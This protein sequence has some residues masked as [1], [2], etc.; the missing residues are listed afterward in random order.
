LVTR[1][2][3][4]AASGAV[5]GCGGSAAPGSGTPAGIAHIDTVVLARGTSWKLPRLGRESAP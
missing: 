1:R 4:R 5:A 3:G 2:P